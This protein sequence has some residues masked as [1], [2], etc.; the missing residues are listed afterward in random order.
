MNASWVLDAV[1]K[2]W[3]VTFSK[4]FGGPPEDKCR[5]CKKSKE[6]HSRMTHIFQE[7]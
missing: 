4:R 1:R 3:T 6:A 7:K 5:L 2:G